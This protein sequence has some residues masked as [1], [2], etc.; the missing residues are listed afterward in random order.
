MGEN[1]DAAIKEYGVHRP[2]I[3]SMTPDINGKTDVDPNL[4]QLIV[5]FDKT[6]LGKGFSINYGDLGKEGMPINKRP[7]YQ[8][9]NNA[10]KLEMELKP[11][12]EY[13]FILTGN[14]FISTDG[15]PLEDYKVKFKTK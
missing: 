13:E 9:G 14:R 2:H 4:K 11:N 8:D 1:I 3:K 10:L 12:T 15:Y 7:E 5:R 6:L